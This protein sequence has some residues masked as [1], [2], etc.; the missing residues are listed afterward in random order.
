VLAEP[1]RIS[2]P[3]AFEEAIAW[4]QKNRPGPEQGG[5]YVWRF[6]VGTAVSRGATKARRARV[7]CGEQGTTHKRN[8]GEIVPYV[9]G[10]IGFAV[11]VVLALIVLQLLQ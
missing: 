8:G 7:I 11:T 6:R 3:E 1:G 5:A 2:Q 9:Y 4:A 10:L